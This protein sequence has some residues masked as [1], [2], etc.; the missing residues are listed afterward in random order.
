MKR[1][2]IILSALFVLSACANRDFYF[3]GDEGTHTGIKFDKNT[4]QWGVNP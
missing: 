2:L 3:N 1:L 4:R